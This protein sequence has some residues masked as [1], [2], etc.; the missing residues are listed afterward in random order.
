MLTHRADVP[1]YFPLRSQAVRRP[2][3]ASLV[4]LSLAVTAV[5]SASPGELDATFGSAGFAAADITGTTAEAISD[6]AIDAQGR[7]V[8]VGWTGGSNSQFAVVR[9]LASGAPDS[10]FG[11]GGV[12]TTDVSSGS[13]VPI[14]VA[15]QSDDKVVVAGLGQTTNDDFAVVRYNTDGSLDSSFDGDGKKLIDLSSSSDQA[16]ALAIQPDGKIVLGGY[17]GT[18]SQSF[19]LVRLGTDGSLDSSFDSDGQV[20]TD[21]SSSTSDAINALVVQ[22]DG[23]LVAGGRSDS[24]IALARY[25]S[26]GTPD[27][28]FGSS[29]KTTATPSGVTVNLAFD[30][31]RRANGGYVVA[32][33][34][35]TA[36]RTFL[37][38][39]FDSGGALD[40]S[41]G[42]SGNGAVLT[43]VTSIQRDLALDVEVDPDGRLVVAGVANLIGSTSSKTVLARYEADGQLDATFGSSG[44]AQFDLTTGVDGAYAMKRQSDGKY[45]LGGFGYS[46]ALGTDGSFT[47]ARV[48]GDVADLSLTESSSSTA[49]AVGESATVSL[50]ATNTGPQSAAAVRL[51]DL[52]PAGT[53]VTGVA[54]SQGSCTTGTTV[55]CSL[56]SL[57]AGDSATVTVTLRGDTSGSD[58]DRAELTSATHDPNTADNTATSGLVVSSAAAVTTAATASSTADTVAPT[59]TL[60]SRSKRLKTV[61]RK[62]K[63]LLR[64]KTSEAATVTITIKLPNGRRFLKRK[65]ELTR[66]GSSSFTIKL[67]RAAVSILRRKGRIA[68]VQGR[69][70]F[71]FR[72]ETTAT[73]A[74]GNR[75]TVKTKLKLRN[76]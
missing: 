71:S 42:T 6:L 11:S 17:I 5:A 76:R 54:T 41:F 34:A 59:V 43:N 22:S 38:A 74:T 15:V 37:L 66:A 72:V 53:T 30:L 55:D 13:D 8:V 28:T 7:I 64:L 19:A 29:G 26:D 3:V 70:Y 32:G 44:V 36:D 14:A 4:T 1:T 20:T 24:A 61:L 18:G 67:P 48:Q 23:K 52:I 16:N 10:T 9:Y 57:A 27:S 56:G 31:A 65:V 12:V 21:F 35:G 75:A 68:R 62:R 2:L 73:D 25:S 63:L 50:T 39:G 45:V 69:R 46:G 60:S 49:L 47:I 51:T 33:E 58:S 40:S